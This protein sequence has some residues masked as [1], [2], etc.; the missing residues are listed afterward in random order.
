MILADCS[1]LG[2]YRTEQ[3]ALKCSEFD[4]RDLIG[5]SNYVPAAA[6]IAIAL[7]KLLTP[8]LSQLSSR[9]GVPV[10]P[11]GIFEELSRIVADA[12][13][14]SREIR[15][16]PDVIYHWPPTFKDGTYVHLI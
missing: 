2:Y 13:Q 5:V 3:R 9:D 16:L 4:R 8:L 12:G 15:M 10:M 6:G 7:R 11:G 14:L 1:I